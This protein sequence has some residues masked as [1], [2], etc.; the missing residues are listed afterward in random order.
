MKREGAM[1]KGD[2][3]VDLQYTIQKGE[4]GQNLEVAG[5]FLKLYV[6]LSIK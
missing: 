4:D 3:V 2:K 5:K 1:N 6:V